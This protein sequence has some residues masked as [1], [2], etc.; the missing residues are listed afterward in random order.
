M[1]TVENAKVIKKWIDARTL[2]PIVINGSTSPAI[3]A[4][5]ALN[6]GISPLFSHLSTS[7]SPR[8]HIQ[9]LSQI[10]DRS[11]LIDF[12][13]VLFDNKKDV[14]KVVSG[15]NLGL[16]GAFEDY[17]AVENLEVL[18]GVLTSFRGVLG[19]GEFRPPNS[20]I[21]RD[22]VA[23]VKYLKKSIS[24]PSLP[25]DRNPKDCAAE[26]ESFWRETLHGNHPPLIK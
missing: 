3:A 16:C 7:L 19:R 25:S 12:A 5:E 23:S 8:K 24:N 6:Y 21:V 1:I 11:L 9:R 17:M 20:Y 4:L 10:W 26:L 15:V 13:K 14:Y 18:L 22:L 2:L